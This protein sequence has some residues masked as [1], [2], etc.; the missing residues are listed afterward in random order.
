MCFLFKQVGTCVH[1]VSLLIKIHIITHKI[2][3]ITHKIHILTHLILTTSQKG[4]LSFKKGKLSFKK[5]KLSFKKGKLSFKSL[6]RI[7]KNAM[8]QVLVSRRIAR[9]GRTR[10]TRGL[11]EKRT[12]YLALLA[13]TAIQMVSYCFILA[14]RGTEFAIFSAFSRLKREEWR[15]EK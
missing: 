10:Q 13:S 3:I 12:V 4:K 11:R 9:L 14:S 7:T 6:P 8:S 2:H 5:G 1:L 15:C